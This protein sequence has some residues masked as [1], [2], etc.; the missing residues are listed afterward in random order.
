MNRFDFWLAGRHS[1][2]EKTKTPILDGCN[3]ASSDT[4][5]FFKIV[6]GPHRLSDAFISVGNSSF[7]IKLKHFFIND[8]FIEELRSV[9]HVDGKLSKKTR[10]FCFGKYTSCLACIFFIRNARL[11]FSMLWCFLF[12]SGNTE[13]IASWKLI[14]R[15][16]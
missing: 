7:S 10:F 2:V 14:Y 8:I 16:N 9:L 12:Y 11:C 3:E 6:G 1:R 5:V 15:T 13:V 4:S